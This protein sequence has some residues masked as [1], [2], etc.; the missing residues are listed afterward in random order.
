MQNMNHIAQI[1]YIERNLTLVSE[2]LLGWK[3]KVKKEF[4][5][6]GK[7]RAEGSDVSY[8]AVQKAEQER[9]QAGGH[10]KPPETDWREEDAELQEELRQAKERKD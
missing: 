7:Q 2:G 4:F 10:F 6:S 9:E 1:I 3:F 8:E 5:V